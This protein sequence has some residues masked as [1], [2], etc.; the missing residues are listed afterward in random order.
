MASSQLSLAIFLSFR[1]LQSFLRVAGEMSVSQIAQALGTA[2]AGLTPRETLCERLRSVLYFR[3][4]DY[5]SY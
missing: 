5:G 1:H 3:F 4:E 2:L